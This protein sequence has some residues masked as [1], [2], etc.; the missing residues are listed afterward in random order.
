MSAGYSTTPL[1]HKLGIREGDR[2]HLRRAPNAYEQTLGTL[3]AGVR[4]LTSLRG[5]FD[6]IQSFCRSQAVLV[7]EFPRLKEHLRPAGRL[8]I[9]WPKKAS[10]IATD[11]DG[12]VV[13]STGL[14]NGLVDVKVCAVDEIWSGLKFVYRKVDRPR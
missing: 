12:G 8:W 9:S 5:E 13:R 11:L 4:R 14:G 3:P 2:I 1:I 10:G 6:F 7:E